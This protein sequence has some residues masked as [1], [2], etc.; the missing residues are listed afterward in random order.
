MRPVLLADG[1]QYQEDEDGIMKVVH[2]EQAL[3]LFNVKTLELS[4]VKFPND[5]SDRQK[6]LRSQFAAA[7]DQD[8]KIFLCGGVRYGDESN[9]QVLDCFEVIRPLVIRDDEG[10]FKCFTTTTQVR[11]DSIDHLRLVG[12][13]LTTRDKHLFLVGGTTLQKA[14]DYSDQYKHN[15]NL[16]KINVDQNSVEVISPPEIVRGKLGIYGASTH[17]LTNN[18]LIILGGST[19]DLTH[20]G[21]SIMA[22]SS[23]QVRM[24]KCDAKECKLD[25]NSPHT[26]AISCDGPMCERWTHWVCAKPV[27]KKHQNKF[28]CEFYTGPSQRRRN[29]AAATTAEGR[30]FM[31]DDSSVQS[32][33]DDNGAGDQ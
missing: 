4:P 31:S 16:L 3:L 32:D 22:W 14:D 27:L 1:H 23:K 24:A 28:F 26:K 9:P 2:P 17:W 12:A 5:E 21:R 10:E 18:H 7:Q 15:T 6:Y 29:A 11:C 33:S 30:N 25:N 20:G 8:G 13:S 19:P